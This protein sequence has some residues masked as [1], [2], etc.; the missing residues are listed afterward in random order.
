MKRMMAVWHLVSTVVLIALVGSWVSRQIAEG[1][2]DE[3]PSRPIHV[4]VPFPLPHS[5]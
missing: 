2:G 3:Y 5:A 4:V 1:P